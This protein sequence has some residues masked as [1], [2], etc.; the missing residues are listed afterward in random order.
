MQKALLNTL[1]QRQHSQLLGWHKVLL[2]I[3]VMC[4]CRPITDSS[5]NIQSTEDTEKTRISQKMSFISARQKS[6]TLSSDYPLPNQPTMHP[7]SMPMP[8]LRSRMAHVPTLGNTNFATSVKP[9]EAARMP[10]IHSNVCTVPAPGAPSCSS[11]PS[12]NSTPKAGAHSWS[13]FGVM[14]SHM[15]CGWW[16]RCSITV[17]G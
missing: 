11:T 14:A 2:E 9:A 13:V 7:P 15:P 10:A 8:C 5:K 4:M 1:K 6:A 16:Q 3:A 17:A 12:T